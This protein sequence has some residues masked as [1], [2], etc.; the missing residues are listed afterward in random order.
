MKLIRFTTAESPSPCFGNLIRDHAVPFAVLQ[1][2]AGKSSPHLTDSRSYLAN[3]PD[4]ERAAKDLA[5]WGEQHL[6]ELT[7]GERFRSPRPCWPRNPSP[8]PVSPCRC[9][10][11]SAT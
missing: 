8:P 6:G 11:T 9:P 7:D 2:K 1:S 5:A 3:L 10:I 4:S